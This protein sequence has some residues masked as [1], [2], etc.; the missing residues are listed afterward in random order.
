[1]TSCQRSKAVT[2]IASLKSDFRSAVIFA[3]LQIFALFASQ[4]SSYLFSIIFSI[5]FHPHPL[6]A[7]NAQ[8]ARRN[9]VAP[10]QKAVTMLVSAWSPSWSMLWWSLVVMEWLHCWNSSWSFSF[11]L[12]EHLWAELSVDGKDLNVEI[13]L[14]TK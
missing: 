7:Q 8:I 1:M 4:S 10:S 3:F 2:C 13:N 9:L 5:M 12:S 11:F 6:I 14:A